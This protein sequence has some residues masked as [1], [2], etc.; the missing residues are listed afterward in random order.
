LRPTS[1]A[2]SSLI[3][4]RPLPTSPTK[5]RKPSTMLAPS[6]STARSS[7]SGLVAGKFVGAIASTNWRTENSSRRFS[8]GANCASAATRARYSP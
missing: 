5:L 8:S 1:N 2:D 3:V 7:T 4:M 6:V